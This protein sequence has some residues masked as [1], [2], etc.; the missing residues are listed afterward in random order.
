MAKVAKVK[1]RKVK[2][3]GRGFSLEEIKKAGLTVAL[4]RELKVPVDTRRKSV[5][6]FNV[7]ELK[8]L[9]LP[10]KK[11]KAK[12]AKKNITSEVIN[13]ITPRRRPV[14]TKPV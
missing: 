9:P 8:K 6:D 14:W 7:A 10:A 1:S 5:Y 2:R 11:P 4:A 13:K 3:K 12:K